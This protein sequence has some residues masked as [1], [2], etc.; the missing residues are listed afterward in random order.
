M[1]NSKIK[2][3]FFIICLIFLTVSIYSSFSQSIQFEQNNIAIEQRLIKDIY[4]LSS[5]SLQGR[6]TGTVG[7]IFTR[8]YI[9]SQFKYLK[10]APVFKDN[11]FVQ[12]F[13][14]SS[15]P[16][17][18]DSTFLKIDNIS[19]VLNKDFY[20]LTN[21][22][23]NYVKSEVAKV[24]Y[25][26]TVPEMK[27]SDYTKSISLKGKIFII[28]IAIPELFAKDSLFKKY[29]N[30]QQKVDTAIARGASAIIFINSD[31]TIP[32]P[33]ASIDKPIVS[34][35]IPVI[36]V[37]ERVSNSFLNTNKSIA[38]ISIG[39]EKKQLTGY[40]VAGFIDNKASKT[41]II[42]GHYD[43]LGL[44][45]QNSLNHIDKSRIYNGA[46][47]NAS[48][49]AAVIELARYFTNSSKKNN[50][51]LFVN[52]SGEEKGAL[53]SSF[54]VKSGV[55]DLSKVNYMINLDMVGRYDS[56]K[57]GL[58]IFGTGTSSKWDSI[59]GMVNISTLKMKKSK[60]ALGGSDQVA[61]YLKDIPV[62]FLFTGS[63]SDYH[64]PSD[65]ADK[66]N[67]EGERAII[68]YLERLIELTD[69]MK[70]LPFVKTDAEP[71]NK[72]STPLKV[73][74]GIIPDHTYEGTG[75]RVDGVMD[76]G[77][78]MKA[79]IMI[80]DVIIKINSQDISDIKSYMK[81]LSPLNKG[82]KASITIKRVNEILVK[83]VEF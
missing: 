71:I 44:G 26:I 54:F 40:N 2:Y 16:S 28:E 12:P 37:N 72:K 52:F 60:S 14:F 80:G 66:I 33:Q 57:S 19:Y 65:D 49:A 68:K 7:E 18:N 15:D 78:G 20:P 32:C 3:K 47:D 45:I 21:A 29:L 81:V 48:G 75:L 62:L 64:S 74:L 63:H 1:F 41:I 23:N 79:G 4:L 55:I 36:F 76:G 6:E 22:S 59:I 38:E 83:D 10:L 9:V 70:K 46:D 61:F 69:S 35:L 50:N 51:Y 31:K 56:T 43:H 67:F 27:Y 39:V 25:G 24:G 8:D 5:D 53:G 82:D 17:Y 58:E 13:T 11:S 34:S 42:G 30:L 77:I 73:S